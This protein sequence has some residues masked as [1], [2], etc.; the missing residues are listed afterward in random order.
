[1]RHRVRQ[2]ALTLILVIATVTVT[3]PLWASL[4]PH[5][6]IG[7]ASVTHSSLRLESPLP[8]PLAEAGTLLLTGGLLIGVASIVRRTG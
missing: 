6:Q 2:R 1:M 5:G 4:T 3:V 7:D 8:Q